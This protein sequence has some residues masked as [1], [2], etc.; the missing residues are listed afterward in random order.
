V[1]SPDDAK[2]LKIRGGDRTM[3][4]ALKEAGASVVSLPSSEIYTGMSSGVL[5]AA[6]TSSTSLISYRLYE[7][8]KFVT[9]ARNRTIWFMF[10]PLLISKEPGTSSPGAADDLHRGRC[11]A[12]EIRHRRRQG[13]RPEAGRGLHQGRRQG[14]RHGRSHVQSLARDRAEECLQG[15]RREGPERPG[16][17][18]H[19][20]GVK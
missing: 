20:V 19:G 6:M 10:E 5:D 7:Q 1:V 12:G 8:S 9:S 18:R 17:A 4:L 14:G 11:L 13:R 16:T 3:E 2:G 15:F